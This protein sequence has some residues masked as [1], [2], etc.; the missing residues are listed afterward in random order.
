M[1]QLENVSKTIG[2]N[3]ILDS[4]NLSFPSHG[5][6]LLRGENGSGKSS[7]LKILAG[8]DARHEGR[9]LF[10][11]QE[12]TAKNCDDFAYRHVSYL[13]QDYIVFDEL[14]VLDNVLFPYQSKDKEK[15]QSVLQEVG[16][17]ALEEEKGENLSS[18]EKA[19][20]AFARALF[21]NPA[22][23][24]ADEIGVNLDPENEKMVLALLEKI[25]CKSLVVFVTHEDEDT[26]LLHPQGFLTM[27]KGRLTGTMSE[28]ETIPEALGKPSQDFSLLK[29]AKESFHHNV[30]FFLLVFLFSLVFSGGTVFFASVYTMDDYQKVV[31]EQISEHYALTSPGVVLDKDKEVLFPSERLFTSDEQFAFSYGISQDFVD[32]SKPEIGN[33]ISGVFFLKDEADFLSHGVRLAKDEEGATMGAYPKESDQILISSYAYRYALAYAAKTKGVDQATMA[34]TFFSEKIPFPFGPRPFLRVAGVYQASTYGYENYLRTR[35]TYDTG[36][37]LCQSSAAFLIESAFVL[38]DFVMKTSSEAA[39]EYFLAHDDDTPYSPS[40]VNADLMRSVTRSSMHDPK[41]GSMIFFFTGQN[42]FD[43]LSNAN[44]GGLSWIFFS[45]GLI[46]SLIFP[47]AFSLA[48]KRKMAMARLVGASRRSELAGNLFMGGISSLFGGLVGFL[49]GYLSLTLFSEAVGREILGGFTGFFTLNSFFA[50]L[51]FIP[52]LAVF[53][54]FS[55]FLCWRICPRDLGALL[56]KWR[57]K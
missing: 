56:E 54:L 7:L 42:Y 13:P 5:L 32:S 17:D 14:S 24:L 3:R 52:P 39:P 35:Q 48:N 46:S 37:Y 1:L 34:Q 33:R 57:A 15:A 28:N 45:L 47:L 11:G 20:L 36:D 40:I 29:N 31:Y 8:A 21:K 49:V 4:L 22:I 43:V 9:L 44:Y 55:F 30:I 51:S 38:N 12:I 50:T 2:G 19:R 25:A 53:I 26:K 23:L 16:L 6:F 27:A 10:D 18:G 41:G